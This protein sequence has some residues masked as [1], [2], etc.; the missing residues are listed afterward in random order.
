AAPGETSRRALSLT[1]PLADRHGDEVGVVGSLHAHQHVVLA[2]L[3]G[4]R[5]RLAKL[6]AAGNALAADIEND[7]AGLQ[8]V[9]GGRAVGIDGGNHHALAAG[10]RNLISWR[11]CHAEIRYAAR[12]SVFGIVSLGLLLELIGHFRERHRDRLRLT[13]ACDVE[14]G[15]TVGSQPGD[16]ARGRA[17][18]L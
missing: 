16:L 17:R 10:T 18:I 5:E 8:A 7:V 14:F 12:R 11:E 6:V 4:L 1:S 15:G 13:L 3:F 2:V 9:L